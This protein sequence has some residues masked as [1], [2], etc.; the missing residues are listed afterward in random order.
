MCKISLKKDKIKFIALFLSLS[1]FC[2]LFY[3]V[4]F[5]DVQA[6]STDEIPK[7]SD[8]FLR[9]VKEETT[10][11]EL[12]NLYTESIHGYKYYLYDIDDN[13]ISV[14]N[15]SHLVSTGDYIRDVTNKTYTVVVTG[16]IDGNGKVTL[17]D[18]VAIKMHFS[19]AIE[20]EGANFAAADTNGD[21][22]V[23]ATDYL[24]IKYHIQEKFNIHDNEDF[25]ADESSS[26]DDSSS[27]YDEE[28][29]T[30]GWM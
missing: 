28:D 2:S 5:S 11:S 26:A 21:S 4:S 13:I 9:G 12:K 6:S 25:S 8:N 10:C 14:L 29:W 16:D 15:Q 17:T 22:R 24:R 20:L 27:K 1:L 19:R 7:I 3:N 30:S 18:T 23:T